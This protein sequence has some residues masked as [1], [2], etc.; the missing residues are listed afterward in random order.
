MTMH[1]FL[2]PGK[3]IRKTYIE[4]FDMSVRSLARNL[5]VAVST[6]ALIA[7]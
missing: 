2:Q 6:A 4:P 5:C 1:N 3:F 7:A